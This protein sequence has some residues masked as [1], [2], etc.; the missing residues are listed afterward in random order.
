MF[1]NWGDLNSSRFFEVG[2]EISYRPINALSLSIEPSYT[3]GRR[4]L[5]YVETL[6]YNGEDRYIMSTLNSEVFSADFR[7][8][9]SITPDLSFQYWGQPFVFAGD[10]TTYKRVTEPMSENYDDRFHIYTEQEISYDSNEEIYHFDENQ[11]GTID[12][13]LDNPNFN[14]FEFRSNFVARWEYIPG[15]TL[16]FVWSQG[17][18]GENNKGE[19]NFRND[20]NDLYSIVPHSVFLLKFSYR[21]SF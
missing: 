3:N 15:S 5:Q 19:F 6:D 2:L 4:E 18:E 16:Y 13:S 20:M 9:F 10:Y 12:Y 17:R 11:D 14:V 1:N 7:I 8:N 21:I